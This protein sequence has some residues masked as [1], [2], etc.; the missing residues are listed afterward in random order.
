M[1]CISPCTTCELHETH[2]QTH[3]DSQHV[4]VVNGNTNALTQFVMCLNV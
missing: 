4:S 2:T 1:Q 3:T